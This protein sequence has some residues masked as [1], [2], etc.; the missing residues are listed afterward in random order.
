[1]ERL[2][3]RLPRRARDILD[4]KELAGG[5]NT[6]VR[7]VTA[8]A[9]YCLRAGL[10]EAEFTEVVQ[11]S[12]LGLEGRLAAGNRPAKW[13]ATLAAQWAF[14]EATHDPEWSGRT[15]VREAVLILTRRVF[16]ADCWSTG[17]RG[18]TQRCVALGI[19]R[20]AYERGAYTFPLAVRFV[21]LVTGV[22]HF[23]AITRAL[24]H[25]DEVGL[26]QFDGRGR[27]GK[28]Y[29]V[30]LDWRPGAR[31]TTQIS[32]PPVFICVS[33]H[34]LFFPAGLGP[35]AGW[36]YAASLSEG[37][38]PSGRELASVLGVSE[39]TVRQARRT[40]TEHGLLTPEGLS[41]QVPREHLDALA[42]RLGVT[43]EREAVRAR[44][45]EERAENQESLAEHNRTRQEQEIVDLDEHHR[46]LAVEWGW[47]PTDL[48]NRVRWCF[49]PFAE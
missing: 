10:T 40:L 27:D 6:R 12:I 22:D 7:A 3:S 34:A 14:A 16:A 24:A 38:P 28:R 45:A 31:E 29:T 43:A 49:D 26:L 9:Q 46:R 11:E 5:H 41:V 32:T 33:S 15:D 20:V 18:I 2:R 30:N 21:S 1:M 37:T 42:R 35:V 4:G 47:I 13:D 25:L 36:V 23:P 44:Y 19:L 48:G 8:V 17:K 39:A